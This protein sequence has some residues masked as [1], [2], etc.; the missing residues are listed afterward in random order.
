M[1]QVLE[2]LRL[3]ELDVL[4][5]LT[6]NDGGEHVGSISIVKPGRGRA[7]PDF[8]RP[9]DD[10]M[11]N[12]EVEE[13]KVE[14]EALVALSTMKIDGTGASPVD[15]HGDGNDGKETWRTAQW[16]ERSDITMSSESSCESALVSVRKAEESQELIIVGHKGHLLRS[17]TKYHDSR[18]SLSRYTADDSDVH[19]EA[20]GNAS[21]MNNATPQEDTAM[22][23]MTIRAPMSTSPSGNQV[24]GGNETSGSTDVKQN[25]EKEGETQGPGNKEEDGQ[26]AKDA[27]PPYTPI[28]PQSQLQSIPSLNT[29]VVNTQAIH[30]LGLD[31]NTEVDKEGDG[32]QEGEDDS[33]SRVMGTH[34]FSVLN[35]DLLDLHESN[36]KKKAGSKT[37]KL[38]VSFRLKQLI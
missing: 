16:N 9:S 3:I 10:E 18:S 1:P 19:Q 31:S 30:G 38:S 20:V 37:C 6:E 32:E 24:M 23:T 14:E 8:S 11:T 21:I 7:M 2:R 22:S 25:L 35:K 15:T 17:G 33:P 29:S 36:P 27:I 13:A 5:R 12:A 4:S 34:R 26:Q 28:P